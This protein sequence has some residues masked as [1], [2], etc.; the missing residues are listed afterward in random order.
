MTRPA[1]NRPS[2][3][4]RLPREL[5]EAIGR[6]RE[7]GC[8]IDE[9][10]AHLQEL[11]GRVSR[12]ALGRHVK[13]LARVGEKMRQSR[14]MAEALTARFGDEPDNQVQRLNIEMLHGIVFQTLLAE[15]G[16]EEEDAE[17]RLVLSAKDAKLLSETLRNLST[18]QK[19]DADR[20]LKIEEAALRKAARAVDEV[21]KQQSGEGGLSDD[22]VA[23]IK[24]KILGIGR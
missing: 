23:I 12:S 17:E 6:L 18:A 10:L 11:G 22:T 21:A 13:T 15:G 9:I 7:D 24:A 4:D 16:S 2:S 1:P 19:V 14:V 5:R 8:T 20:M 3:I